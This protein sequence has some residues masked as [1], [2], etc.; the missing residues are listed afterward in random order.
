MIFKKTQHRE[1]G[2]G[3]GPMRT[4]IQRLNISPQN[5]SVRIITFIAARPREGTS[6][7]AHEYA[8]M[9]AAECL[10]KV[11]LINAGPVAAQR[12]RAYGVDSPPGV[13]DA[14]LDGQWP[15]PA[16]HP[17]DATVGRTEIGHW[18]EPTENRV[19]AAKMAADPKFWESLL[20]SFDTIVIDG[21]SLQSSFDGV[22][23]AVKADAT[24]LVVE[25]ESTPQPV[26]ENLRDTL[27]ASGAKLAGVVMNKRRY[28]IPQRAY[29]KL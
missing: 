19:L 17:T 16:I 12:F 9:L 5:R 26:V 7:I 23:L 13:I 8:S 18:V 6:T 22:V 24:V 2:D 11:L 27:A 4:L 21:P 25:A 15:D 10:Q 20:T 14:M 29:K 1:D 28:Y 3:S